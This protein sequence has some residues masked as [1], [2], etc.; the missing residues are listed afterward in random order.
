MAEERIART[1]DGFPP[2]AIPRAEVSGVAEHATGLVVRGR[3]GAA[4]LVPREVDGYDR[5]RA[6]LAGWA[7]GR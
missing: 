3:D 5:A 2:I 6:L 4:L 1:V 7:P